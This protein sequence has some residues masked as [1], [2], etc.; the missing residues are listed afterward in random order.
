MSPENN[1]SDDDFKFREHRNHDNDESK[2]QPGY[3]DEDDFF[4]DD[5][6][7]FKDYDSE[8]YDSSGYR[9][10]RAK[11]RRRKRRLIFS[12]I[13]ILL[14]LVIIA[15]G[16]VFGYRFIKNKFFSREEVVE[17]AISIP[18][19]ME[20]NQDINMVIAGAR[21]NLLEPDV[22]SILYSN[23]NSTRGELISLCIPVKTLM[24]IP[25][26]GLE[27]VDKSIE[28]GGMD[29]LALTLKNGLGVSV[30]HYIL[31]DIYTIVNK[32]DGVELKLDEPLTIKSDDGSTIEL[33]QGE[34]LV[35]GKEAVSFL[36]YFSGIEDDVAIADIEKQKVLI[37]ALI[38]RIAGEN[39][40]DLANNLSM[41]SDYIETDLSIEQLSKLVAT[42]SELN[43]EQDKVHVLDVTS[44]ELEGK[45]F[46]VPD[47]TRISEIFAQ[48]EIVSEEMPGTTEVVNLTILNGVGTPGLARKVSDIFQGLK[49]ENGSDK[50]N[51]VEVGNAD[52]FNYNSTEIIVNSD[53]AF[54]MQAAEE[55]K[56]VLK[57]GN[58]STGEGVVSESD[59]VIILGHDYNYDLSVISKEVEAEVVKI[60]IL[61]GEGTT[62][63]AATTKKIIEDYFNVEEKV[64]EVVETKNA[65]NWNYSQ[66]E[67]IIFTATETVN[68]LA[69]KIQELL[70][71]GV[72]KTSQDNADNVDISIILGSDYTN[73]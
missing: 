2:K 10:R 43:A 60:N 67:I 71:V 45:V 49:Y 22:N 38:D 28:Y 55:I 8:D 63:L 69:Q 42:F 18:E 56:N 47:I 5:D 25:G 61:N 9:T 23:Y 37:D 59:I 36:K 14:I 7:E 17:E 73:R 35:N 31:M 40:K 58:I 21:E 65:D 30:D 1:N 41:I 62:G 48:E 24:E 68:S 57:A 72:I 12:T 32:L 33:K 46:Y 4:S 39:D 29:L 70:G 34:D 6:F 50:Y 11:E 26:F 16:I 53:E 64:L 66:T 15:A 19:S 54:V 13:F 51:V 3:N 20:L 27:S 44:V 52:N